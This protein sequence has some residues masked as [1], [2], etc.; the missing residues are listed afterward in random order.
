VF[1]GLLRRTLLRLS[2]SELAQKF[3]EGRGGGEATHLFERHFGRQFPGM[4]RE[5]S[6][7]QGAAHRARGDLRHDRL[8]EPNEANRH[9]NRR[10]KGVTLPAT[11]EAAGVECDD[12]SYRTATAREFER[13]PSSHGAADRVDAG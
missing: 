12:R 6:E 13:E 1:H 9:V 2:V 4:R 10:I 7:E 8:Q 5:L 3:V 11:P